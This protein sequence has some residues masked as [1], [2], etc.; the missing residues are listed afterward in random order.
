MDGGLERLVRI[1]HEFCMCPPPPQ[2]EAVLYGLSAP[3]THPP[4]LVPTLNP[5]SY[6]KQAATRFSLAFQ[7]VV[8]IGVRGSEQIRGRVVQAGT[9]DVVGCILEAWL[10][11]R[12]FAVGPSSTAGGMYRETR[13]QRL[14]R[15]AAQVELKQ[16]EQA[17]A[18]ARALQR[19]VV[20]DR[21]LRLDR[22]LPSPEVCPATYLLL[23]SLKPLQ[24]D[25]MEVE[26]P[27]SAT[28]RPSSR[29]TDTSTEPSSNTTP[30]GSNTPTGTVV[31]PSRDRS[32]TII[33]RPVWDQA[34]NQTITG[35]HHR[36]RTLR[37][38]PSNDMNAPSTSHSAGSSRPETET[39]DDGDVDMDG[40]RDSDALVSGAST[41]ERRNPSRDAPTVRQGNIHPR[42]AVGIVS[43]GVPTA[44][45]A[46]MDMNNDAHI[47][48]N[49]QTVTVDGVGMA[50]GIV[51]LETNDDFAMGAPP[52]APGA[53]NGPPRTD[54]HV[55]AGE[56]TPRAGTI[57]LPVTTTPVPPLPASH[58][59]QDAEI[60]QHLT[61]AKVWKR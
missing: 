51:S 39:E 4:K 35:H 17:A 11:S 61:L 10:A 1:L 7:S 59:L 23:H 30:A 57:T 41:P 38:R 25:S 16:R 46:S 54:A 49:D 26:T 29:D 18:L 36:G 14:A 22:A 48:I 43:D 52:G 20:A 8:N 50:D 5:K 37:A 40:T 60:V 53:I 56:R 3:S 55:P 33:A 2:N 24:D 13:E 31:V 32:G 34:S 15:K 45:G 28:R 27:A 19:Q 6:D 12:G 9:L 44:A 21:T 58:A 47:I 42:R